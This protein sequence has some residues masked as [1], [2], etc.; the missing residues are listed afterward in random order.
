M[1]LELNSTVNPRNVVTRQ[2][3]E[4]GSEGSIT[5]ERE[6]FRGRGAFGGSDARGRRG[7][8]GFSPGR[9]RGVEM[10]R[11]E[12]DKEEERRRELGKRDSEDGWEKAQRRGVQVSAM[13]IIAEVGRGWDLALA[14]IMQGLSQ[15]G[16]LA[17]SRESGV[18]VPGG[19]ILKK[20]AAW[21]M[22]RRWGSTIRCS[23]QSPSEV[24][25]MK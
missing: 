17:I 10:H 15:V 14:E 6:M 16:G 21:R 18:R 9:N 2:G 19:H 1:S 20:L 4:G 11:W 5:S 12:S 25:R 13:V 24:V 22:K 23:T 8:R 7:G 3:A